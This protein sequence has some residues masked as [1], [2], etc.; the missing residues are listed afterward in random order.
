MPLI[1]EILSQTAAQLKDHIINGATPASQTSA[2]SPAASLPVQTATPASREFGKDQGT[3]APGTQTPPKA[4]PSLPNTNPAARLM[5]LGETDVAPGGPPPTPQPVHATPP[6]KL[7]VVA[8]QAAPAQVQQPI[9]P[10]ANDTMAVGGQDY[11]A[12]TIDPSVAG[13]TPSTDPVKTAAS[14]PGFWNQVVEV[15]SKTGKS[16]LELLGDFA[17][18]YAGKTTPTEQRLQRE[19]ELRM[20]GNQLQMQKDVMSIQQGFNE[21]QNKLQMD[22]DT[23]MH[24]ATNDLQKQQIENEFQL[25]KQEL[26]NQRQ[27]MMQNYEIAQLNRQWQISGQQG[28]TG[29]AGSFYKFGQE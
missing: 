22:H 18:G 19:H 16:I 9:A 12:S 26:L 8:Q 23:A 15:A 10:G 14:Q 27:M 3:V 20:Q 13:I 25:R 2:K 29:N 28:A 21:Q 4:V 5:G 6:P 17:A 11:R 7:P 1:D 24:A